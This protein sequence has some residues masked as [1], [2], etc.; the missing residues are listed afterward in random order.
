[1]RVDLSKY[2]TNIAFNSKL[3]H[4]FYNVYIDNIH[5]FDGFPYFLISSERTMSIDQKAYLV[6]GVFKKTK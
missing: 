4:R 5:D 6:V 1:M 3:I 2:A